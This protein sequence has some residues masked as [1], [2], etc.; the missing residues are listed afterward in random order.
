[1]ES[2]IINN[3]NTNCSITLFEAVSFNSIK[4]RD[5]VSKSPIFKPMFTFNYPSTP[6]SLCYQGEVGGEWCENTTKRAA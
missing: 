4:Q 6:L 1:M 3:N 5:Y 2:F